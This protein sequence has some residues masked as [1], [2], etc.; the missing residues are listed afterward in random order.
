VRHEG[1]VNGSIGGIADCGLRITDLTAKS[2]A[3]QAAPEGIEPRISPISRIRR[4]FQR[5]AAKT[6]RRKE[7][8]APSQCRTGG[9]CNSNRFLP[10]RNAKIAEMR[11]YAVFSL[12]S[13]RSLAANSSLVAAV[14]RCA[15]APLRFITPCLRGPIFIPGQISM[16][17]DAPGR[18]FVAGF[19]PFCGKS[20]QLTYY[21]QLTI[22]TECFQLRSN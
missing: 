7:L 20:A 9:S 4:T 3:R 6:Q 16:L 10:Q 21:Q 15:F 17:S 1:T 11:T 22:K 13:M 19:A 5:K 8:P 2:A 18:L 12:R 14:P